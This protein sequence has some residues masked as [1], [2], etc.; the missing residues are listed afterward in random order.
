M[1]V[2][3][4]N[5]MLVVAQENT[6]EIMKKQHELWRVLPSPAHGAFQSKLGGEINNRSLVILMRD[7]YTKWIDKDERDE[8]K[9][10]TGD[11]E[12]VN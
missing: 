9:G 12:R 1:T 10:E 5:I 7:Q 8:K 2:M 4:L 11:E 6:I 3:N